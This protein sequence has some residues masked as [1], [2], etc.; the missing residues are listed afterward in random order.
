MRPRPSTFTRVVS[1]AAP[2]VTKLRGRWGT[3]PLLC[4]RAAG[5]GRWTVLVTV[6][7]LL[8]DRLLIRRLLAVRLLLVDLRRVVRV[9]IL[10]RQGRRLR[11]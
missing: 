10:G 8:L 2:S 7:R 6:R 3:L 1:A 9:V 11:L 4:R 5:L